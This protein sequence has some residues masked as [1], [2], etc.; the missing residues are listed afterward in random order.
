MTL[1]ITA[2]EK[3]I[4]L[5]LIK[6]FT[7]GIVT[8]LNIPLLFDTGLDAPSD[9]DVQWVVIQNDMSEMDSNRLSLMVINIILCARNDPDGIA[10]S[11]LRDS[12]M[13]LLTGSIPVYDTTP[14]YTVP[15]EPEEDPEL[16]PW[17]EG[18]NILTP[19]SVIESGISAGTDGTKYKQI[20][21]RL[22]FAC[23]A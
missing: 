22:R 16:I 5:S 20:T 2:Q 13:D 14:R 9:T 18:I 11:D 3:H 15:A 6:Y 4:R 8:A 17:S 7:D 23:K 19:D 10:L 12:V 21:V 1:H